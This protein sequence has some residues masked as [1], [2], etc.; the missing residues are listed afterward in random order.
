MPIL[1]WLYANVLGNLVASAVAFAAA[2]F[3][4]IRPHFRRQHAHRENTAAQLADLHTKT[5]TL[6]TK[7]TESETP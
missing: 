5:D 3:W 1:L 4:K 6:H 7:I 2:W